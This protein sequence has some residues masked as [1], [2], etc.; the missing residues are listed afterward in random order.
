MTYGGF[1]IQ[2]E[3]VE[4]WYLIGFY[5]A[6]DVYNPSPKDTHMMRVPR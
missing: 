3:V 2:K 5:D 4:N 6:G 1:E